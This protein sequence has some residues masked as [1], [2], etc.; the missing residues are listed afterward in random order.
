MEKEQEGRVKSSQ[1]Q[2]FFPLSSALLY[3]LIVGLG[4]DCSLKQMLSVNDQSH[5]SLHF[6]CIFVWNSDSFLKVNIAA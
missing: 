2:R 1:T 4:V 3:H 5:K 6:I